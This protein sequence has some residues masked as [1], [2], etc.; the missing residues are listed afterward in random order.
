M[1]VVGLLGQRRVFDSDG[2]EI[3]VD[4]PP[5]H[6][7]QANEKAHTWTAVDGGSVADLERH[8]PGVGLGEGDFATV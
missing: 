2:K 8:V 1:L 4:S 6:Q 3:P 5:I 7:L